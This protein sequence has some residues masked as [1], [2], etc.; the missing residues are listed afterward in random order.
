VKIFSKDPELLLSCVKSQYF[1]YLGK[2][3]LS[4]SRFPISGGAAKLQ[5]EGFQ[6]GLI[7][8]QLIMEDIPAV[9]GPLFGLAALKQ[10]IRLE[11]P[12][13]SRPRAGSAFTSCPITLIASS[14]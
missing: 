1:Y 12:N 4:F 14:D 6:S 2:S 10:G 5:N 7:Q 11:F 3:I 8:A 13:R 9:H